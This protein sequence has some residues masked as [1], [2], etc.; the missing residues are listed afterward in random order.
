M[1]TKGIVKK[2]G[3]THKR[4]T[5]K[6]KKTGGDIGPHQ[7]YQHILSIGYEI[8]SPFLAKLTLSEGFDEETGKSQKILFNTD[9]NTQNIAAMNA[10][11]EI[12]EEDEDYI[13]RQ[14][15]LTEVDI[16]NDE[17][18]I[19]PNASFLITNDM[20]S[21]I[22]MKKLNEICPSSEDK[23][24]IYK[25]RINER[26]EYPLNFIFFNEQDCSIFSDVEW[27]FTYYKPQPS[28]NVIIDTFANAMQN[29]IRHIKGLELKTGE[30]I[31][32]TEDG[33]LVIGHPNK[34]SLFHN[35]ESNLYYLQTTYT[36]YD[37]KPDDI[38]F[39]CQMTFASHISN[40]F[41]IMKQMIL[42]NIKL[43]DVQT[44]GCFSETSKARLA[45]LEKTEYCVKQLLSHYNE[46]ETT[47]QIILTKE[48][49]QVF[50]AIKNYLALILYKLNIYYNTY[51]EK[52]RQHKKD[53]K[54]KEGYE[55][56]IY[57]KD[58]LFL[59]PRHNNHKLYEELKKSIAEFFSDLLGHLDE[60][61][62]N[63]KVVDIIR[64]VVIQPTILNELLVENIKNVR[65]NAF[66]INNVLEKKDAQYGNPYYSL[67]SYFQF[68]EDP[69]ENDKN[70]DVE[71]NI[72][73]YDWLEYNGVDRVSSRMDIRDGVVLVEVRAFQRM[74]SVYLYGTSTPE[75]KKELIESKCS[76][77]E[78]CTL[79]QSVRII[80]QWLQLYRSKPKEH[81]KTKEKSRKTM[82][83][84]LL[85]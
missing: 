29:L 5:R 4:T 85:P 82:K 2:R 43:D 24:K 39:T 58:Y 14:E 47:Y 71:D 8:E 30:L 57:F 62:R 18:K 33:E 1:N 36:K 76:R 3:N 25:F 53:K 69:V 6:N 16:Y 37:I 65:K 80:D 52:E 54:E 23:N 44:I 27:V 74:L 26:E 81:S 64:K 55:K 38:C 34:R 11:G 22:F 19:D 13:L 73:Y 9:S 63:Q 84:S 77:L 20:T 45:I 51:L 31:M 15:E 50:K 56:N 83:S 66:N 78:Q 72:L 28:K 7:A 48:K 49:E 46:N 35:P 60:E 17:G 32:N 59:N 21:S 41:Y 75:L 12:D 70:L 79:S 40:T 67:I 42:D 68:F 10:Q 61:E